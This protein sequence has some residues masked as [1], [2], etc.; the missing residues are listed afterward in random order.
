VSAED[1]N[2]VLSLYPDLTYAGWIVPPAG[3]REKTRASRRRLA[4]GEL[5]DPVVMAQFELCR[6]FVATQ[7][8]AEDPKGELASSVDLKKTLERWHLLRGD[9]VYV[10]HG[11]MLLAMIS[12][13]F[14]PRAIDPPSCCFLV[15]AARL[16][17]LVRISVLPT[18]PARSST[19]VG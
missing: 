19:W 13:G 5:L 3:E 4:R 14:T 12:A 8:G 7:L 9:A 18:G 10:C 17:S 16:A 1:I 15:S 2:N 11:V 6:N